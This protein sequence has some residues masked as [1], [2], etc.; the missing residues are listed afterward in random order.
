MATILDN[1]DVQVL[2][3]TTEAQLCTHASNIC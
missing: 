3:V 1:T 2:E